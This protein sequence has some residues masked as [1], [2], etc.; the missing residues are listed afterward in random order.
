M[1][2]YLG[3]KRLLVPRI[4]AAVA[5][6]PS[7][8]T[9]LDL[10]S[11][12]A[13]VGHAL[14]QRGIRVLAND[15]CRF[16]AVF[17][18]CYVAAD[19]DRSEEAGRLLHELQSLPPRPGWFTATY[20]EQARYLR[21]ENGAKVEAIREGI[22]ALACDPELEAVLLT[23]LIEAADRVDSTTGVQMAYL[24][25]WAARAG[26]P[27]VLRLP[28]LLPQADAGKG[29]A[30]ELDAVQAAA[31]L[32]CDVAYLDPPYNQHK[33][34]GNY[35]V[36][37]TVARW[38]RP[39]VFGKARKRVDCR[40][41]KSPFN[42]RVQA[43]AALAAVIAALQAR[44]IVV[45]FSDEG[46]LSLPEIVEIL[47]V[48]GEPLVLSA[49]YPRY[50]GAK[51]GIHNPRGEKVGQVGHLHNHERLFVVT[52]DQG[53]RSALEA[54]GYVEAAALAAAAEA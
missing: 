3:S 31:A 14:K 39:E 30:F 32:P 8:R 21:P 36:W 5:A 50:V 4:L 11:G 53:A 24:K 35:H 40:T 38:D 12:T 46:W 26:N 34:L 15:H 13:R 7:V 19:R 52:D 20:C 28:E 54:Q 33:Y 16:A 43:R 44:H 10:F 23:S 45:S 25:Q 18:R 37:E 29:E 47:R 2:K 22:A 27:L 41:R 1:I 6:L 48:R 42:S 51:I 17:A 49:S 9:A